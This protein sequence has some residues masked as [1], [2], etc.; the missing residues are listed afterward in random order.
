MP[1]IWQSLG[2]TD[3]FLQHALTNAAYH[4]ADEKS[5]CVALSSASAPEQ[6]LHCC[7]SINPRAKHSNTSLEP[8]LSADG[9]A[10]HR[11]PRS[12]ASS[13]MGDARVGTD[14]PADWFAGA[15]WR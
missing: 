14:R 15:Q 8:A 9:V 1:A 4:L 11:D 2:A 3:P 10:F 12:T 13:G 7:C 5:L 6:K